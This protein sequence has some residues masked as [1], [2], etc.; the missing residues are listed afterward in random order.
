[1]PG[2]DD[3]R[4]LIWSEDNRIKFNA[5]FGDGPAIVTEGYAGWQVVS[6]PKDVGI[7]TWQGR[8]PMAIEIPFMLDYLPLWRSSNLDHPGVAC[9]NQVTNLEQL[10]GI[11][12]HSQPSICCVDGGG[13]IPHDYTTYSKHRWV[14]EQVS[15][16]RQMEIR[17][18][19]SGRRLRCGGQLTIRQYMTASEILQRIASKDRAVKPRYYVV[20]RGDNL[21]KI[22]SKFYGDANKWKKIADVNHMRDHRSLTIGKRIRIP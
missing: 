17:S 16:D 18:Q 5:N 9:E 21:E 6:R 1:M 15:W 13:M 3:G 11:G 12:G 20:K 2:A 10:C 8:N 14:I 19:H 4:F 7:T 22:A